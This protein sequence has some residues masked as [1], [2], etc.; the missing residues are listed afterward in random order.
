[1][2]VRVFSSEAEPMD[3]NLPETEPDGVLVPPPRVPPMALATSAPLPPRQ[4]ALRS[5]WRTETLRDL[6]T[7]ALDQLDMLGDRIANAV[8]LR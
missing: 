6:A 8:G 7:A 5:P 4:P 1:M 3:E 2:E